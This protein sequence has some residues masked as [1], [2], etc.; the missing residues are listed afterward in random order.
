[1]KLGITEHLFKSIQMSWFN[2]IWITRLLSQSFSVYQG[3]PWESAARFPAFH[4]S[5]HLLLRLLFP[6]LHVHLFASSGSCTYLPEI[7]F[8]PIGSGL[9]SAKK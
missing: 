4:C 6:S 7:F 2:T 8:P 1:M 3:M 9:I 5:F